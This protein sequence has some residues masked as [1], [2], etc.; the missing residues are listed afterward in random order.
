MNDHTTLTPE[1]MAK[2]RETCGMSMSMGSVLGRVLQEAT[3]RRVCEEAYV[4]ILAASL[5]TFRTM[6]IYE[7]LTAI[8]IEA[9][10]KHGKEDL[11]V[12]ANFITHSVMASHEHLLP[13]IIPQYERFLNI[14]EANLGDKWKIDTAELRKIREEFKALHGV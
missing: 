5:N 9:A 1:E 6:V 4:D 3:E 12:V 7:V 10:E 14:A 13:R 11:N 2:A 8:L